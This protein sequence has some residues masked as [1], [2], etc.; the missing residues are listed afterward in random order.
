MLPEKSEDS[1]NRQNFVSAISST[2]CTRF[3]NWSSIS[4]C[5][6]WSPSGKYKDVIYQYG[7]VNLIPRAEI[8]TPT[9]D[10][11][12]AV[13]SCPDDLKESISEDEDFNEIMSNILIELLANQGLEELNKNGI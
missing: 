13:R 7:Q 3:Q 12:R 5:R 10:F 8:E 2:N 1:R 4:I 6:Y 9:V 11:E